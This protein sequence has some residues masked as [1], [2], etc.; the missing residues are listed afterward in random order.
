[1]LRDHHENQRRDRRLQFSGHDR[2]YDQV[3]PHAEASRQGNA[4]GRWRVRRRHRQDRQV[5]PV[6]RYPSL[7]RKGQ[8]RVRR[9]EQG[10]ASVSGRRRRISEFGR[11][12]HD[13]GVLGAIAEA[14][15]D[16]DIVY[17]DLNMVT[18]HRSKR[19]VRSWRGGKFRR[20][21]YQLGWGPPHP[22]FYM[23]K[24]VAKKVGDYDLS[25]I[26]TADYD[27]MLRAL[28]LND[29][30]V[31][32][33]PRIFVDFQIGGISKGLGRDHP[34]QSGMSAVAPPTPARPVHR[35]RAF[36][37]PDPARFST[38]QNRLIAAAPTPRL[39]RPTPPRIPAPLP[40]TAP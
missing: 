24:E 28:A 12:L 4:G 35:R 10:P 23:R 26:T 6:S 5:V 21:A 13:S 29:F 19:V 18:D 31:R 15:Q 25:Y 1:M 8:G 38:P 33:L 14:M 17:G 16:S 2:L 3:L 20:Y 34:G 37:P 40:S 22:S 27:Y 7:V 11:Y 36:S 30:R 32:Y 39:H 9:H